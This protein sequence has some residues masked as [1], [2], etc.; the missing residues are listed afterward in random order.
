MAKQ[1]PGRRTL[2]SIRI[3]SVPRV[4]YTSNMKKNAFLVIVLILLMIVILES[5]LLLNKHNIATFQPNPLPPTFTKLTCDFLLEGETASDPNNNKIE[6]FTDDKSSIITSSIYQHAIIEH[7]GD[8]KLNV[9]LFTKLDDPWPNSP[10]YIIQSETDREVLARNDKTNT[11]IV[12][13]KVTGL[14]LVNSL[15]DFNEEFGYV[16]VQNATWFICKAN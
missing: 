10:E 1:V 9:N 12:I 7:S 6:S 14:V 3:L 11:Q 8:K 2:F 4:W 13:S 5:V 16:P 15:N